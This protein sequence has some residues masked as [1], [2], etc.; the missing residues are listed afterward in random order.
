MLLDTWHATQVYTGLW[1]GIQVAVKVLITRESFEDGLEGEGL[2]LPESVQ[3]RQ[4]ECS[5]KLVVA[6]CKRNQL[7]CGCDRRPKKVAY[8]SGIATARM[9]QHA[10]ADMAPSNHVW[11]PMLTCRRR[12]CKAR[13]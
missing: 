8:H 4:H 7:V 9:H 12:S 3:V 10:P 5:I 6:P 1:S 2:Q 11:R 13:Q